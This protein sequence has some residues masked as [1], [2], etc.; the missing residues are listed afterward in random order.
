MQY[1]LLPS[2]NDLADLA[3][4]W[5]LNK[6]LKFA[7]PLPDSRPQIYLDTF[8]PRVVYLAVHARHRRTRVSA[9]EFL[10][11]SV[12]FLLGKSATQTQDK[13]MILLYKKILPAV[14]TLAGDDD[15]VIKNLFYPLLSQIIHWLT[16][17]SQ[18][19]ERRHE[20]AMCLLDCILKGLCN[21][22]DPVIRVA[23]AKHLEEYLRW[24]IKQSIP[25][26]KHQNDKISR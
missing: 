12:L 16:K 5:D 20:E 10:H 9:C 14:V 15:Q 11:V 7:I 26:S 18:N 3:T 22:E 23:S 17:S 2:D 4:S 25:S 21:V 13:N 24:S 8:L 19:N 6:H 1:L